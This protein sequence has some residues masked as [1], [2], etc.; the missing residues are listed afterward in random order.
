MTET[1]EELECVQHEL[2]EALAVQVQ[3]EVN[4]SSL[5]QQFEA[6]VRAA[7]QRSDSVDC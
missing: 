2:A 5:L 6:E 3:N 4:T 1:Q 7:Q